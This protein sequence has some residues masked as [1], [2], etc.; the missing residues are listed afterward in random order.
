M[1]LMRIHLGPRRQRGRQQADQHQR[2]RSRAHEDNAGNRSAIRC[3]LHG[4]KSQVEVATPL[5]ILFKIGALAR[6]CGLSLKTICLDC[7]ARLIQPSSRSEGGY[8]LFQEKESPKV[9]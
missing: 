1:V 7:T 8:R 5:N 2:G 3:T 4:V 6:L 9:P